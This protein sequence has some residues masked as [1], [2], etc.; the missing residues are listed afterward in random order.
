MM[1]A[2]MLKLTVTDA[3]MIILGPAAPGYAL[4]LQTE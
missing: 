3:L 2:V 4:P 1:K